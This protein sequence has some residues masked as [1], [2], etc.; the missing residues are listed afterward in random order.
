MVREFL[1]ENSGMG[2]AKYPYTSKGHSEGEPDEDY[3]IEWNALVDEVCGPRKKN[4]DGDPKTMEDAAVEVAKILVKDSD[5]FRDVL[6]MS[7]ANKSLGT[8]ILRQIQA[9][10]EQ[11]NL[12]N[13][14]KV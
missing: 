10:R 9:A 13:E 2:Y 4:V 1:N 5:L 11:K 12:D 14:L 8:E 6:E 3:M 7:G